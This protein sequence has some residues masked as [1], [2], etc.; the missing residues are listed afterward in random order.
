[1]YG[2]N[3]TSTGTTYGVFGD[4]Y[5]PTGY[6]G[7]FQGGR[8]YIQGN[9][10]IGTQTPGSKLEVAGQVKITGGSPGAGKVLTSDATGLATWE[11]PVISTHNHIGEIW[12]A[13]VGW[14]QAAFK[15]VNSLNGPS[16]WG[17]NS[18]GGNGI[19]G[20]GLNSSIGVYGEGE[21]GAGVKGSSSFGNGVEG[22]TTSPTGYSGFFTGE[23]FYVEGNTGIGTQTPGTKL[24][25]AGQV[26]I[27]GGTPGTGK[28]LTSDA[29]G[30]A[31]W[32]APELSPWLKNGSNL[33]YNNG[34]VAIGMTFPRYDL[35]IYNDNNPHIGFYNSTSG[36]SGTDGFTISTGSSGS[37]VW[38]W[39]WENSNMH[40]GTN[41]ANR[42][43]INADGQVSYV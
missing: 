2:V 11:T 24:E 19:R 18:G 15:V 42:M 12:N 1:M 5:S 25:V 34:N 20:E 38:I 40:F 13:S 28:V 16:I 36:T 41:N 21:K 23:R 29:A 37:P 14:S 6:S 10:G 35:T 9:T 4:V 7:Y 32:Q 33:Y 8:F 31:S 43:I 26:K 30:L 3:K 27:T 39:N 22:N 17:I